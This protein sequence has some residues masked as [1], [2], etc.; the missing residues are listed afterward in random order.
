LNKKEFDSKWNT[1]DQ[2]IVL[3]LRE[4]LSSYHLWKRTRKRKSIRYEM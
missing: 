4:E 3:S 1:I 2:S